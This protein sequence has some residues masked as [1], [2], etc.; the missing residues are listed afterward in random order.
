ML[1]KR[2]DLS[3][4]EFRDY[5]EAHHRFLRKKYLSAHA[6]K[7]ALKYIRRYHI[8]AGDGADTPGFDVMMEVWFDNYY[9]MEAAMADMSAATAQ[10]E[11]AKDEEQLFDRDRTKSSIVDECE[12]DIKGDDPDDSTNE[13]PLDTELLLG[14]RTRTSSFTCLRPDESARPVVA[15]HCSRVAVERIGFRFNLAYLKFRRLP[16]H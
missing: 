6:L 11:L 7:Y 15:C 16:V 4:E 5:Y 3:A 2:A 12:S 14:W 10:R 8:L 13:G 9:S 1:F